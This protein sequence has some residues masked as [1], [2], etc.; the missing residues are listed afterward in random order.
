ML[1]N[2]KILLLFLYLHYL[3]LSSKSDVDKLL[4]FLKI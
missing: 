4:L 2:Q 3:N 1:H